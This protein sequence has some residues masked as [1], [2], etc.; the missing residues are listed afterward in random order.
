MNLSELGIG[1]VAK[2]LERHGIGT[3]EDLTALNERELRGLVGLGAKSV[4]AVCAAL[5]DRG[6]ELAEDPWAPYVCARH[7]KAGWDVGLADLFLCDAC[8]RDFERDAFDG[9][10]PEWVGTATGGYCLNCNLEKPDVRPRQWFLCGICE[11][12]VRSIGRS[13]VAARYLLEVWQRVVVDAGIP[14]GLHEVDA[15]VLKRRSRES[16][17]TKI[18]T[19][20]FV[21]V[22]E[23]DDPIFEIEMKTGRGYVRGTAVGSKMATFQLDTS[24]CDDIITVARRDAIPVYLA[25][26]QVIDRAHPPTI[27]YEPLALWWTDL[28]SMSDHFIEART[29]P[30][31]TRIAAYYR[32]EM[33]RDASLLAEHLRSGGAAALRDRLKR[34]GIPAIYRLR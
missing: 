31:E 21:A 3:T 29:R 7:G 14:I 1:R 33:F 16:I 32:T 5:D 10:P 11:R 25:H 9:Q 13:V 23:R 20:D 15:P 4:E 6:L 17:A 12:V 34:E 19:A 8:A 22:D 24:D 28:F 30:R 27:R 2:V 18:A 26:V